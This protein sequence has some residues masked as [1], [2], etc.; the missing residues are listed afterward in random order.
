MNTTSLTAAVKALKDSAPRLVPAVLPQAALDRVVFHLEEVDLDI[1][2][3]A[4]R[5]ADFSRSGTDVEALG[6][7]LDAFQHGA[8]THMTGEFEAMERVVDPLRKEPNTLPAP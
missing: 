7:A 2:R 5:I 4:A 1:Q 6:R 3:L 8:L